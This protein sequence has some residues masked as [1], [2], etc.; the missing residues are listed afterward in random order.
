MQPT[1]HYHSSSPA[2][3]TFRV[4][5]WL[6]LTS[7]WNAAMIAQYLVSVGNESLINTLPTGV[8]TC[9]AGC[10]NSPLML[11]TAVGCSSSQASQTFATLVE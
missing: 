4:H 9:V 11:C 10:T 1:E 2:A 6:L 8:L 3:E 7:R 5:S